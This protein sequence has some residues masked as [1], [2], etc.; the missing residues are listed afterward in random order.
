[1]VDWK[2]KACIVTGACSGIGLEFVKSLLDRKAKCLMADLNFKVG[3]EKETEFQKKYGPN[4]VSYLRVDVSSHQNFE[5]AFEKCLELFG[6]VDILVNSAGILG[7]INWES[8]LQI[9][10]FGTIR[11]TKLALKHMKKGGIVLNISSVHG[12][13]VRPTMPT[14]SAGK[15]GIITFTRSAGHPIEYAETGVKIVCLCPGAVDTPLGDYKHHI[16]I[17]PAAK[18][19]YDQRVRAQLLPQLLPSE[20]SEAGIEIMEKAESA[21]VW[22]IH[23]HGQ[24]AFEIPNE[25][26]TM[27]KLLEYQPQC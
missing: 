12:L 14:Y 27:E 19:H 17:T 23:T 21:S 11:G 15:S 25:L 2:D 16:G 24:K 10:L 4:Q 7:E 20:V 22:F 9:N 1:M 3:E 26:D 8:Q 6:Q 13:Q 18:A 5:A